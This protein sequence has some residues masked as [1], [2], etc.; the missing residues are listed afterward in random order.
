ME[1]HPYREIERTESSRGRLLIVGCRSG[2]PQANQ[3]ARLYRQEMGAVLYFPDVDDRFSDTETIVNLESDVNGFDVFLFQALYD[4][5]SD[6]PVD[7]NYQAFLMTARA[8]LE[9]GANHVTAILPYLAYARQDKSSSDK[10]EPTTARLMA[11]FTIAA[12]VGRLVT[13]HPHLEQIRGF[14]GRIPVNILDSMPI[15]VEAFKHFKGRDDVVAVSPDAG[16]SKFVTRFARTLNLR[17]AIA[18]KFRPRPEEAVISE[19]IGDL[20][21]KRIAIIVDDMI[22][23]GGTIYNLARKLVEAHGIEEIYLGAAHNLCMPQAHERL[24]ELH[25]Q[26]YL[27]QLITTDSIS[28]TR[29]FLRLPFIQVRSLSERLYQATHSIHHN[30]SL[31]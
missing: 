19:I 16:A 24:V 26:G 25:T 17:T 10:L 5:T 22:S 6:R 8:L 27:R 21:K 18:A 4:P 23:S 30:R 3:V 13:F 15:W 1:T 2:T 20:E 12:G 7:Q 9:W 14:Y 28:Q 11:D 29:E 31:T